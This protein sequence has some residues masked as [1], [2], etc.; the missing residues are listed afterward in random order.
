MA[1]TA[2]MFVLDKLKPFFASEV[3]LMTGG[4]EEAVYVRAVTGA[5][6]GVLESGR[7]FGRD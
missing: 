2:V 4:R 6:E 1:E 5:R 7:Q 3:Q